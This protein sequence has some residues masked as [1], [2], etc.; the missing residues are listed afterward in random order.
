MEFLALQDM[1]FSDTDVPDI[2]I[3]DIM[4]SLPSD[5]VK[6]YIYGLF[7]CKHSKHATL[8]EISTKLNMSRD[9]LNAVLVALEN[10]ELLVRTQNGITFLDIKEREIARIYRKKDVSTPDEALS[11]TQAS[12]KRSQCIESMN[13][14][15]FQGSMP[16]H[17]YTFVDN[18]F[19]QYHFDEDVM[20]SL[21][22]YCYNNNALN[23]KY[24]G[25]VAASWS[26]RNITSHFELERYM[27]SFQKTRE[28]GYKIAKALNF[29][30]N[31]TVYE[32]EFVDIWANQYGY[33][34]DLVEIAL[35]KMTGKSN[36]NFRYI[37]T[38]LTDWYKSGVKTK[39]EA[40]A[41]ST[42]KPSSI[43]EPESSTKIPQKNNFT[44]RQYSNEFYEKL[45]KST[46][47]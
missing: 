45:K 26:K 16:S 20:I 43:K 31:L 5:S 9:S 2:F 29:R 1:L 22:Q 25:Q 30:R 15:F 4:P 19:S 24:V 17:W 35:Q 39:E 32:E 40:L 18:L 7:L 8:D 14:M 36:I 11:N 23:K 34:M 6:V 46:F 42:K 38:I 27:E 33:K 12:Q 10:E 37:N 13:Q 28:L 3:C 41:H 47:K 21:F 44:Q